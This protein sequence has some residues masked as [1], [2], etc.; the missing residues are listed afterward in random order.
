MN[1]RLRPL[2]VSSL[3]LFIVLL[4]LPTRAVADDPFTGSR[5]ERRMPKERTVD[6]QHM[7]VSLTV[8]HSER[9]I[10]GEAEITLVPLR[11]S[12]TEV[13]LDCAELL[14]KKVSRPD[15]KPY[16]FRQAG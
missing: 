4:T 10:R 11:D 9:R 14:V 8:H 7:K 2:L 13:S 1:A 12:L 5:A 15:G 6:I 3:W 16:K